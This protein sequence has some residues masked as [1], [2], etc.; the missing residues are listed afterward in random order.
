MLAS[1]DELHNV[2]QNLFGIHPPDMTGIW[3]KINDRHKVLFPA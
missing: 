2:L 1:E 3:Q